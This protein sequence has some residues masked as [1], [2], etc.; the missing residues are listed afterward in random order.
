VSDSHDIDSKDPLELFDSWLKQAQE[1]EPNDPSAAALA[2]STT[3]GVPS[4][5]VVLAKRI[6]KHHFCFFTN[7]E[8]KKGIELAENPRAAMCFH[9]KALRRQVRLEGKVAELDASDVDEYFHS[10]SRASQISA[11][12]S[13]QSRIL[14]S[15]EELEE[16]V[17]EFAEQHPGEIPRPTFWK[18]FHLHAER[19]EFWLDGANRLHDRFLFT[20][21]GDRWQK[22]RLYP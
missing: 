8:S 16:R 20:W 5:R 15:R 13:A 7:A 3:N 22:A 14:G 17:R 19:I 21:D 18:G 6:G 11:A 10:R 4:V 2:T 1:S 12:V 9:W